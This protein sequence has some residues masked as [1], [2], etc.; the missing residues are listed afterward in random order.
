MLLILN[1][2]L[3]GLWVQI[4]RVP[5]RLLFPCLVL[6]TLIGS[7]AMH[8]EIGDVFVMIF[9]GIVGYLFRKFGY[10][11][12]PLIMGFILGPIIEASLRQSLLL[13]DGN[14]LVFFRRP[15]SATFLGI[16]AVLL[17]L[18]IFPV[19]RGKLKQARDGIDDE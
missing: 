18:S 14:F 8:N 3:I 2:P 6:F 17:F 10:A 15:I 11:G 16:V 1:L 13:F 12:A 4:L 5:Y 19:F 9:F 7:Y